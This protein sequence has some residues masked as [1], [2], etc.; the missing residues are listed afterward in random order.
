MKNGEIKLRELNQSQLDEIL[1][2]YYSN[3]ILQLMS[4]MP[5]ENLSDEETDA[6]EMKHG[7]EWKKVLGYE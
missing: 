6:L 5:V 7:L 4:G 1:E 2:D 3:V